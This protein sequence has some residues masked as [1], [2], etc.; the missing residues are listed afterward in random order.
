LLGASQ[1]GQEQL[2]HA[3]PQAELRPRLEQPNASVGRSFQ[4]MPVFKMNRIAVSTTRF[5]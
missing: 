1:L 3:L 5:S 2:V 4:P